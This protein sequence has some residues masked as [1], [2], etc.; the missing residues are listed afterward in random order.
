MDTMESVKTC[1][2]CGM[3]SRDWKG[4][5]GQGY[6]QDGNMYCCEGCAEFGAGACTCR[7]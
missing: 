6:E 2:N 5:D 1:P 7:S 3:E 4:N